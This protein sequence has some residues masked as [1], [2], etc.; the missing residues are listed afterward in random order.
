MYDSLNL[1]EN[2][3]EN[4]NEALKIYM[5]LDD[6]SKIATVYNYLGYNYASLFAENKSLEFYLKSLNCSL[7][8]ISITYFFTTN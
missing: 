3:I 7:L 5:E 2:A 1:P 6:K 8:L 4:Y